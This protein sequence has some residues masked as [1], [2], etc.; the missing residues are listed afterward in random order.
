MM[1]LITDTSTYDHRI[2]TQHIIRVSETAAAVEI[3][4]IDGGIIETNE[5]LVDITEKVRQDIL[6]YQSVLSPP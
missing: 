6:F 1:I 5:T 4:L 2:I 3:H